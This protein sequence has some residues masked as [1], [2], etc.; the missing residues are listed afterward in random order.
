MRITDGKKTVDIKMTVWNGTGYGPEWTADFIEAGSLP[1]DES[2][3][4]YT[5]DDVDYIIDQAC[6]WKNSTGD[7]R[8]DVPNPNNAVLIDEY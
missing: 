4:T 1:Y 5:V 7:F 8:D 2:T 6:D 3:D